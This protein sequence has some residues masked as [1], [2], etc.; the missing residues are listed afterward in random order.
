MGKIGFN[1][2]DQFLQ[3]LVPLITVLIA[4]GI[5]APVTSYDTPCQVSEETEALEASGALLF[6]SRPYES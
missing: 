5:M 1:L 2:F 4:A 3:V 6:I